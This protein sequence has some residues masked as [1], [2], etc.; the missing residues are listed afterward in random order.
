MI[1]ESLHIGAIHAIDRPDFSI[2]P[3]VLFQSE[4]S[5]DRDWS[6]SEVGRISFGQAHQNAIVERCARAE[7]AFFI[8]ANEDKFLQ[9]RLAERGPDIAPDRDGVVVV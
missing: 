9:S 2:G 4:S 3:H 1:P 5:L 7:T 8:V 6:D